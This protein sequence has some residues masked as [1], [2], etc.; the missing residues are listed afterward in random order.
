MTGV[1]TCALPICEL[2][3]VLRRAAYTEDDGLLF[4]HAGLDPRRSLAEQGDTL[5]WGHA[6]WP[7]LKAPY[8]AYRCVVRGYAGSAAAPDPGPHALTLDG[9]CG[10]GG[11]LVA[12][13][14]ATGFAAGFGAGFAGFTALTGVFG[15]GF[16]GIVVFTLAFAS[17]TV[18]E[19]WADK[20]H[21]DTQGI[22]APT[23]EAYYR[24]VKGE[25]PKNTLWEVHNMLKEFGTVFLRTINLPPG[26]PAIA[27]DIWRDAIAAVIRDEEYR[28][29]AIKT[30][31][32]VPR[33]YMGPE[34]EKKYRDGIVPD[35]KVVAFTSEYV[36][37][38]MAMMGK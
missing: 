16:A 17:T 27:T 6:A 15:A 26:A 14:L 25:P 24:K 2:L 37:Q 22:K 30:I 5:W 11:P 34:I 4:V 18:A 21:P 19:A 20:D 13:C 3:G 7:K 1:Q 10:S 35:P 23:F 8:A 28:A 9:G 31:K 36:K 33:F 38:G 32:Y 29:D 12:A